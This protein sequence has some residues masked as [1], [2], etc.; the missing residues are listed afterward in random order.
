MAATPGLPIPPGLRAAA[1]R[2]G[3]APWL[4]GLAAVVDDVSG[5]WSLTVGPPFEPGGNISWV[6]PVRRRADDLEAVLK[7]QLPH[8]ESD[9]EAAGL[10]AWGGDGAV[11][12]Y[13]HDPERHA[14]LIERCVPGGALRDEGGTDA[15]AEVGAGLG[16]RLHAIP[17]P[18]GMP[19]LA[20]VLDLWADELEPRLDGDPLDP[21][22]ARLV[23]DTMRT[24][25]R[26]CGETA[27]L[28]GDLNPTNVLSARREPWLAIDPK[29]VVGDPAY[30]GPR[31]VT[32]PD[33]LLTDDPGATIDRRLD[34][35]SRTMG[36]DRDVL[37]VWCLVGAVEMGAWSAGNDD[38][39]TATALRRHVDL[40]AV[41]LP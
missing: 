18:E 27:L 23:L 11:V 6:A 3:C 28:H 2:Y 31:L 30:D 21:G 8:P 37:V 26:A 39:A 38:V 34:I 32:Q 33:P 22:L 13:D 12:L 19:T 15:A 4:D 5:A 36:I 1:T 25:P 40:L 20:S 17:P 14:L 10:A 29:P 24:R 7:V 16:A 9:P 41:R 35:V